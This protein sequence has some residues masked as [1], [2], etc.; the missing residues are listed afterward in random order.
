MMVALQAKRFRR[1]FAVLQ[2]RHF[3]Q[4]QFTSGKAL[5]AKT[6]KVLQAKNTSGKVLQA[7]STSGKTLQG[8]L[9]KYFRQ[10]HFRQSHFR[11]ST[12]GKTLQANWQSTSDKALQAKKRLWDPF[13]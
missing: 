6:G 2:A 7:K 11:Q 8:K 9:A 3:K 12:S 5:Q 4:G 13:W 10:S 1:A